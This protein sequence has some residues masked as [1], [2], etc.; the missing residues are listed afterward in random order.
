VTSVEAVARLVAREDLSRDETQVVTNEI[1]DGKATAAQTGAFLAAQGARGAHRL[2]PARAAGEP[3]RGAPPGAG[4]LRSEVG[5]GGGAGARAAGG[6]A[7]LKVVTEVRDTET[8]PLVAEYAD[9]LKVGAR[10]MQNFSLL[11]KFG[12]V[13]RPVLLERGLSVT[14]KEL[15]MAA[16][17][18]VAHG[19]HRVMLCERGIRTFETMTRN[20]VDINA[21]PVLKS[22]SHQPVVL[23]PSHGIGLRQHVPAITRAGVAA[24]ADGLII[25]VHSCPEKAQSDGQQSLTCAEFDGLMKQVDVIARALGTPLVTLQRGAPPRAVS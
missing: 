2:Q 16:E 23:D 18:I 14:L 3:G 6:A 15:L 9:V 7:G 19:N 24:G 21:V 1:A 12:R 11:E 22:L 4:R 8:L 13:D 5:A 10:N 25:E 20:T 17:S